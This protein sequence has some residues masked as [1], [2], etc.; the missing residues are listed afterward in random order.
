[1]KHQM[2]KRLAWL[3]A[4]VS[5][6]VLLV[7]ITLSILYI[8][9]SGDYGD[10]LSHQFLVPFFTIAYAI[11]GALVASRQPK[12]AIGW[13][14]LAVALLS[15]LNALSTGYGFYGPTLWVADS[16]PGYEWAHWLGAWVWIPGSFAPT[17]FVF[18]LFPDGHLLSPRWRL[19]AWPAVL[20]LIMAVIGA[21]FHPGPIESWGLMDPNPY[22]ITALAVPLE[23]A[24]NIGAHSQISRTKRN[25]PSS[26]A[27]P[28]AA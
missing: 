7:G 5:I 28:L 1:M 25:M 22:G 10:I 14:F 26:P 18:L 16:F 24:L 11:I 12:N 17:V 19:V 6:V 8:A 3:L 2:S 15:G 13:L 4:A 21:A 23:L 9:A 20:G 27:A